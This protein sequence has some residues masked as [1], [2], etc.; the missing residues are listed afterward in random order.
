MI[1]E[2]LISFCKLYYDQNVYFKKKTLKMSKQSLKS[3]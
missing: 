2:K 1:K 3:V